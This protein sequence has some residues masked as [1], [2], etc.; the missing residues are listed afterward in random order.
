VGWRGE[1]GIGDEW[2]EGAEIWA[3]QVCFFFSFLFSIS[4]KFSN[5]YSK[6]KFIQ[7]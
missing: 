5:L 1:G 4:F 7:I 3:T 6:F 2:T